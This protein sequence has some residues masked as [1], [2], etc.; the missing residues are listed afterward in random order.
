MFFSLIKSFKKIFHI[1]FILLQLF[2]QIWGNIVDIV[3]ISS[4]FI[5]FSWRFSHKGQSPLYILDIILGTFDIT[6]D[7]IDIFD[8]V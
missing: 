7:Q 3:P 6:V 1:F 8:V 5:T 4:L 2:V